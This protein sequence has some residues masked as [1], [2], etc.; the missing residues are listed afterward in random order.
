MIYAYSPNNL[1]DMGYFCKN[2]KYFRDNY[3]DTKP[4]K[5][6]AVFFQ[7]FKG[8]MGYTGPLPGPRMLFR[9]LAIHF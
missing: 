9:A 4:S 5:V 1:R 2:S 3:G 8:D 7:N 6:W